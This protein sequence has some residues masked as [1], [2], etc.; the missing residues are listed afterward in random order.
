LLV[1]ISTIFRG[2]SWLM[3]GLTLKQIP[4]LA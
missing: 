4:K 1:G 3:L 2:V